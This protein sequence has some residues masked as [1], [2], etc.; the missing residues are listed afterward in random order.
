MSTSGG[1]TGSAAPAPTP[2]LVL[3]DPEAETIGAAVVLAAGHFQPLIR[4]GVFHLP[5]GVR[6]AAESTRRFRDT[7][8]VVEAWGFARGIEARVAAAFSKYDQL[9]DDCDFLTLAGDWPFRYSVE[10]GERPARGIYRAR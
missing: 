9:G 3:A 4:L 7:L 5:P 2:G 1:G 6:G 8:T 10:E